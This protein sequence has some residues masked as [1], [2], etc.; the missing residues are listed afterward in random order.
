MTIRST[1]R[2]IPPCDG[3]RTAS[4]R[5]RSRTV[6][7]FLF[8]HRQQL[9][10]LRLQRDCEAGGFPPTSPRSVRCR[11]SARTA[12]GRGRAAGCPRRGAGNG[13][14]ARV[15]CVAGSSP[16]AGSP[17]P[18]YR[19]LL[20]HELS[21][22][23]FPAQDPIAIESGSPRHSMRTVCPVRPPLLQELPCNRFARSL[24]RE[25]ATPHRGL[26]VNTGASSPS[27]RA[28]AASQDLFDLPEPRPERRRRREDNRPRAR[29]VRDQRGTSP[30]PRVAI[31]S[32]RPRS[33]WRSEVR[34]VAP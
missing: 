14:A 8:G 15:R 13:W 32:V 2:A 33:A 28:H 6:P 4:P 19:K 7:C 18:R 17:S 30:G 3:C 12:P 23:P 34:L 9:E 5:G 27:H 26:V 11:A 24:L 21:S 10:D 31:S 22:R 16:S 1:P 25:F 29:P 20:V